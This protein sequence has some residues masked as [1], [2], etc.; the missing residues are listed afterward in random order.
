[1]TTL[2]KKLKAKSNLCSK[3]PKV[4]KKKL[5]T[6]LRSGE[7]EQCTGALYEDGAYCVM[8]VV[9]KLLF[10]NVQPDG[11]AVIKSIPTVLDINKVPKVFLNDDGDMSDIQDELITMNDGG[12]DFEYLADWIDKEL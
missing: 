6:A 11:E 9:H 1:M 12:K 10:P 4:F 7:F 5:L 3:L 2:E 8:G